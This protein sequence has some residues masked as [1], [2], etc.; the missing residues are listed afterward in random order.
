M[1]WRGPH[2][3]ARPDLEALG[4]I[5]APQ[6]RACLFPYSAPDVCRR[7][8]PYFLSCGQAGPSIHPFGGPSRHAHYLIEKL[9]EGARLPAV[10]PSLPSSL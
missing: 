5:L 7:W 3:C 9:S 10:L 1:D 4:P 6:T 8:G 2:R